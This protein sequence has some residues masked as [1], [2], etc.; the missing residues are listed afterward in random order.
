[1]KDYDFPVDAVYLWV[2]GNDPAW[3]KRKDQALLKLESNSS[4]TV[5]RESLSEAR[6]KDNSEL[7]YSLRSLELHAP[8]INKVHIITDQQCPAWLNTKT[9]NL[10]DH[11]QILP[12]GA[13][14]PVFNNRPI[15]LCMH[16]IPGLSENFLAFND[17]FML[18]AR[19]DKKDFYAGDGKPL[20][21]A[22]KKVQPAK[23]SEKILSSPSAGAREKTNAWTKLLISQRFGV[24]LAHKIKHYP[25]ACTKSSI[26]QL[27]QEFSEEINKT[28]Q[29]QFRGPQD[30]NMFPGYPLFLMA[31]RFGKP[32]FING[33]HQFW[34]FLNKKVYHVGTSLADKNYLK[35]AKR[36]AWLKP[37]TFCVNDS[38]QAQ[39]AEREWLKNYLEKMFPF[40]SKYEI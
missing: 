26:E 27:W 5:E 32:L 11:S 23:E 12:A 25:R 36:I 30:F 35:K 15:E 6:F 21:W 37:K 10:V 18:G 33:W 31:S 29:N 20:V 39:A 3:N 38:A 14:Y 40:K 7:L 17:D 28:I 13:A 9:V 16:R 1:M 2:D 4:N 24:H 19:V 34:F 22:A 8:W